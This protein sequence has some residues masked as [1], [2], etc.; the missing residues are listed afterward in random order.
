MYRRFNLAVCV[1]FPVLSF[2]LVKVEL[3]DCWS[4]IRG[5]LN[6][7]RKVMSCFLIFLTV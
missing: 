7:I 1:V 4:E 3:V 2:F 6:L 5:Y